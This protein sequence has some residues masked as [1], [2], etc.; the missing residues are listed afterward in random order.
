MKKVL[1]LTV[2][3]CFL[4][5]LSGC[6]KKEEP[7]NQN[8]TTSTT[9]TSKGKYQIKCAVVTMKLT[10][11]MMK[12]DMDI[13]STLYFD[14]YGKKEC[15]ENIS[16]ISMMGQ[17]IKSHQLS[18]TKD[19]FIYSLDLEK[20]TGTK[21]KIDNKIDP[22]KLDFSNLSEDIIKEWNIK[23][24]GTEKILDK[25]CEVISM[26]NE[27]MQMT[28]KV[29]TWQG[30]TLKSD[31]DMGG[32]NVKMEATNIDVR[33]NLPESRFQIPPDI[34]IEEINMPNL[35]ENLKEE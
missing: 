34:K 21:M 24:E 26:S 10:N 12:M 20:K 25:T 22:S 1:T 28:G 3:A 15:T 16:Q 19:D 30:I 5:I 2:L 7:A 33:D 31:M 9:S 8:Q 23:K 35:G 18:I 32:I 4:F 27:K 14:E 11:N 17:T 6:G 29:Y 13:A